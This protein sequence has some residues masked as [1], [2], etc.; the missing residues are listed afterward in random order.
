MRFQSQNAFLSHSTPLCA[1]VVAFS[2]RII[3]K[4]VSA[5][6]ILSMHKRSYAVCAIAYD[7][8][9]ST[10]TDVYREFNSKV[11][12]VFFFFFANN[13]KTKGNQASYVVLHLYIIKKNWGF[14]ICLKFANCEERSIDWWVL[15]HQLWNIINEF[16]SNNNNLNL[17]IL[18]FHYIFT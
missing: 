8:H 3:C 14:T 17:N 5:L 6:C 4:K 10:V 2:F 13:S 12:K 1:V 11:S 16:V 9:F 18:I 15:Y 7:H